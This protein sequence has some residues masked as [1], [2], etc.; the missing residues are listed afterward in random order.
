V[1]RLSQ[2]DRIGF[3]FMIGKTVSHYRITGPLGA[4]G[5]G[6]VY[7][8]EDIRLGR[9][10]AVKFVSDDLAKDRQ[11]VERLNSEARTASSLNHP[12][13]CTIYDIGDFEGQPFIVME[14]LKGQTLRDRMTTTAPLKTLDVIEMGIQVADALDAAHRRDVIHRDIKPANLF[15][16]DRGPVKVLDFG[17]AKLLSGETGGGTTAVRSTREQTGDGVTLGT[18]SYMSPEQV[19]GEEL[20]GRS[21]LFSLGVVLYEALTGHQPF[22]GKT[23]AVVFSAILTHAPVAPIVLNPGLP[24]RLQEVINNCLEKDRELR[25]QDAAGLRADLK[26]VKRDLESGRSGV[27]K[28]SGTATAGTS[29]SRVGGAQTQALPR[30][31]STQV[32]DGSSKAPYVALAAIAATTAALVVGLYVWTLP[33][34]QSRPDSAPTGTSQAFLRS[35]LALAAASVESKNYRA[36]LVYADEVI[37]VAPDNG[38]AVRIRD[39]AKAMLAR[40]DEAIASADRR[41]GAGDTAGATDAL[42]AARAIDP[43]ASSVGQLSERIAAQIQAGGRARRDAPPA[44]SAAAPQQPAATEPTRQADKRTQAA[45]EPASAATAPVPVAPQ[46]APEPATSQ[47]APSTKAAPE[48]RDTPVAAPPSDRASSQPPTVPAPAAV[49]P[50]AVPAP[51][52]RADASERREPVAPASVPESDDALIRRVVATYARAIE[53]KDLS[54]F[55]SVKPNMSTDEQRRI[56]QGFRAVASQEISMSVV[57]I[58]QKGSDASVRVRRRDTIQAGGRQQTTESQQTM[59]L[60]RSASGWVIREIGR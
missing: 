30:D 10:V 46:A 7:A 49:A 36:A 37:R 41:L 1:T 6:V 60:T 45:H 14:L 34:G 18:V 40:F 50:P 5:M 58:E 42:N 22:T 25:Y 19:T 31:K 52:P 39:A 33:R 2:P 43:T 38:E 57:S 28:V 16:V 56:E 24:L 51:A 15:L 35:Q 48:Q 29:Q 21:D 54:L 17:L 23:S 47:V 13:I 12:N 9:P 53:T 26:R 59:T 4:G 11:I 20:D 3:F 27:F 32:S 8:G 44:K 55:R